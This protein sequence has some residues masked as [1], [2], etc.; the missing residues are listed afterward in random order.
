MRNVATHT[1]LQCL[2]GMLSVGVKTNISCR[3]SIIQ[4]DS[5]CSCSE[6]HEVFTAWNRN[7]LAQER[8]E[9][10]MQNRHSKVGLYIIHS[11]ILFG[12]LILRNDVPDSVSISATRHL[13]STKSKHQCDS[14]KTFGNVFKSVF[15]RGPMS[16]CLKQTNKGKK[17][18]NPNI[19]MYLDAK[20]FR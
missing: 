6:T 17:Q 1:H 7:W 9:N 3:V 10:V 18:I 11:V 13:Q 5:N 19:L 14:Q 12:F 8:K 4:Y 2:R 16:A 20:V 15:I